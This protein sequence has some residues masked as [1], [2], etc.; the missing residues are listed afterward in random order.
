MFQ[1]QPLQQIRQ[2]EL[3][4]I[5]AVAPSWPSAEP[6]SNRPSVSGVS[7]VAR[8]QSTIEG[9]PIMRLMSW[10]SKFV[11]RVGLH[12]TPW[13]P[14]CRFWWVHSA[15]VALVVIGFYAS[16]ARSLPIVAAALSTVAPSFLA[17]FLYA[18]RRREHGLPPPRR[19]R[20]N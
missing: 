8:T 4:S 1:S 18:E 19:L 17:G 12:R 10:L 20:D 5:D 14:A 11:E 13:Y 7:R 3:L 15:V 9:A 16:L 2:R 6:D